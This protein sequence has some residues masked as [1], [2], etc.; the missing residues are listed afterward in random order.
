MVM[1]KHDDVNS[2]DYSR[3]SDGSDGSAMVAVQ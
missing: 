3:G 2:D 1:M